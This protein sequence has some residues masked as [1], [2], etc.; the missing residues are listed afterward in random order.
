MKLRIIRIQI[1]EVEVPKKNGSEEAEYAKAIRD[2]EKYFAG[3]K[4][5]NIVVERLVK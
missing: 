1:K 5:D 3:C 2:P 4:S